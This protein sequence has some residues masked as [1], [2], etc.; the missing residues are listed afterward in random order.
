MVFTRFLVDC[1]DCELHNP[2]HS[3][4]RFQYSVPAECFSIFEGYMKGHL[5]IVLQM[6]PRGCSGIFKFVL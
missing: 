3:S 4:E 2:T 5:E 6:R 1:N